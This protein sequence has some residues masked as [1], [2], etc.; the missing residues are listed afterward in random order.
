MTDAAPKTL[1]D[2]DARNRSHARDLP[3]TEHAV[4]ALVSA[5]RSAGVPE[6]VIQ[7]AR[8]TPIES[9]EHREERL[10]AERRAARTKAEASRV[11]VGFAATKISLRASVRD[12]LLAGTL[13]AELAKL[14]PDPRARDALSAVEAWL[15]DRDV[16]A[17]ALIGD[18]GRGKTVASAHAALEMI[19]KRRTVLRVVEPELVTWAHSPT[20]THGER[21]EVACNVD[22]LIVDELGT[23]LGSAERSRAALFRVLDARIPNGLRTLMISNHGADTPA[24]K[25]TEREAIGAFG[26]A[27]GG[28]FLDRM[29][30][31]GTFCVVKGPS[32]RGRS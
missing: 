13:D 28:R 32:L 19:R 5:A 29:R 24:R 21:F 31:I 12:A 16:Q 26:E 15:D 25:F 8:T 18:M 2:A 17:L 30:E 20:I 10:R 22:L 14:E 7:R 6:D 3:R 4:D 9:V 1:H 27:Y 23:A 11:E